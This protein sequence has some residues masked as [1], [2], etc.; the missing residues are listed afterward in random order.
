MGE[1]PFL[2]HPWLRNPHAMTIL[3]AFSKSRAKKLDRESEAVLVEVELGCRVLIRKH[4]KATGTA[5]ILIIVHGLEG[6]AS[7][8][9]VLSLTTKAMAAGFDVV[10]MNLRN[11]GGTLKLAP[12]LYNGGMSNDVLAV[13]DFLRTQHP[14]RE[15]ILVGYSLGG[16]IV[17]K[18][19]AEC[20]DHKRVAG[21]CAVSPSIDLE[22]CVGSMEK[23]FNRIYEMSFLH[24]LKK[25]VRAKSR[26]F[27][28]R[29]DTSLLARISSMRAFD[30][31]ITAPD[32]G[33]KNG[34]DYYTRASSRRM[35]NKIT[36]PA[37]IVIAQDD[38]IVPFEIFRSP[39]I[40]SKYI[41]LLAPAHGGHGGFINNRIETNTYSISHDRRW[42][43]NRIV[44]FC[45][46][47]W[48]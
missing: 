30:D 6:S 9:Y 26:L 4:V 20:L 33:Y 17:L 10:R 44:Q 15:I 37:L 1:I 3:P 11:C 28:G 2:P 7:S 24:G 22:A 32:G 38:P 45:L 21:V 14:G 46:H 36:V 40:N 23:G 5:P 47:H 29:F 42:A 12:T 43:E 35:L 8:A 25:K 34:V 31:L 18:A 48:R 13:S 41:T 19:A 39:Q 16:N 27:P